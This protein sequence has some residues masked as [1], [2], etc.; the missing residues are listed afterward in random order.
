MA[1]QKR[2]ARRT[3]AFI[4]VDHA[5]A[6]NLNG[7]AEVFSVADH[8]LGKDG[9]YDMVFLSEA[10]GPIRT[11]CGI[12][13]STERLDAVNI[14]GLDTL[15]VV[16]GPTAESLPRDAALVR[17]VRRASKKAR[18]TCTV[19]KGAFLL[20]AA[21]LLDGR[22]VVTHWCEVE[23]L[24]ALYPKA[25]VELDPIYLRDGGIWTSAGMSAGIDL[26]LALVEDDYGRRISL[27]VAKEMV[28]FLHR[29]GG[30]AQFSS[31]LAAQTR[32]GAGSSHSKMAE[33]P[34]WIMNHLD[35]DLSVEGL[36]KSVGMSP[37][38]FARNFTRWHG[39]TPAK[40][41]QDLRVEAACRHLET[42]DSEVKR[43]ADTC[44]FGDEERMRRAF[45][46][47]LG[48]PPAAYRDRFGS[49][50]SAQYG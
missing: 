33:L 38:T 4:L 20:G 31:A 3:V 40:L 45:I 49:R 29:S 39:G 43:I 35:A 16:G 18:R 36:A 7:P 30:Q 23:R 21:G 37:R 32:L 9:G 44:G 2:S 22:R 17:W 5:L 12:V 47:R 28:I 15:I 26:A 41:V 11:S 19:C 1:I 6:L 46:R 8:L 34:A 42:G 25:R 14:A 27:G 24:Q 13:V 10:G 48:I 50:S